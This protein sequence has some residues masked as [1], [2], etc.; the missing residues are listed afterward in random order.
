MYYFPIQTTATQLKRSLPTIGSAQA[1]A[2]ANCIIKRSSERCEEDGSGQLAGLYKANF[3]QPISGRLA[4]PRL[5][6]AFDGVS[7]FGQPPR[8]ALKRRSR[9]PFAGARRSL[10][11]VSQLTHTGIPV[12]CV[13]VCRSVS[14][15]QPAAS[16]PSCAAASFADSQG[17]AH[18]PFPPY[19]DK[20]AS[21]AAKLLDARTCPP[22]WRAREFH[23]SVIGKRRSLGKSRFALT[24]KVD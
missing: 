9:D 16:G 13:C 20:R 17:R 2:P 8:G 7:S 5:C 23:T 18:A 11:Q 4:R 6:S 14:P 24:L 19:L 22:E 21:R 1:R 3:F 12:S 15:M 10:R